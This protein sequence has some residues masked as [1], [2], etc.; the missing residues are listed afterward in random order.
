[1]TQPLPHSNF[2]WLTLQK[3]QEMMGRWLEDSS[4]GYILE[5][6]M[7]YPAHLHDLHNDYPLAPESVT[8]D[9]QD[10]SPY[11]QQL[12]AQMNIH[13]QPCEKLVPNLRNKVHYKVHAR[14][15]A[16]YERLGLR[17][18]KVHRVLAFTQRAWMEPYITYNNDRRRVATSDFEKNLFKF[19]NNR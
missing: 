2:H 4:K 15:L 9:P 8:V 16:L 12:R 10:L 7:E 1:M 3:I 5:V 13:S 17:V 14:N 18:T 11:C 19:L 6:D